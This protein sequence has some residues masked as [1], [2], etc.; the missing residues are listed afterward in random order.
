MPVTHESAMRNSCHNHRLAGIDKWLLGQLGH[1][2]QIA[3]VCAESSPPGRM[4]V[5]VPDLMSQKFCGFSTALRSPPR[6]AVFVKFDRADDGFANRI[7]LSI[8]YRANQCKC[9]YICLGNL[10]LDA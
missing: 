5:T 4:D 6:L 8:G 10:S 9:L 7:D 1:F 2:V 3:Q